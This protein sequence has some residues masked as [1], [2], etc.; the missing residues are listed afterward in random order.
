MIAGSKSLFKAVPHVLLSGVGNWFCGD[1]S[2]RLF[3]QIPGMQ[4]TSIN[5]LAGQKVLLDLVLRLAF[6]ILH[7]H[8]CLNCVCKDTV[9]RTLSSKGN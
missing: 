5:C 2:S 9:S 4:V 7:S 3:F 6:F 1:Y 8:T